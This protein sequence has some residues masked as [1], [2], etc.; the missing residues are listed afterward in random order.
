MSMRV[1]QILILSV[2]FHAAASFAVDTERAAF[3][4]DFEA[5]VLREHNLARTDPEA[6]AD[7]LRQWLRYYQGKRRELPGRR[8]VVTT[9]GVKGV[10]EAIE[11]LVAVKPL[12]PLE[13][14]PGLTSAARD[15]VTDSGDKGWMGHAG[16]DGSEPGD[17]ALRYGQWYGRVGENIVY[18]G[19]SARE[20]VIRLLI[21]DGVPTRGHRKNIFNPEYTRAGVAFGYHDE[22]ETMCVIDYAAEFEDR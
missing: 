14:S 20:F 19:S 3:L 17:R 13:F 4:S 6:Y 21:D 8:P 7:H 16:S 18:G 22:Y 11:F 9:E 1:L 5:N 2:A 10:E 12:P 15:H